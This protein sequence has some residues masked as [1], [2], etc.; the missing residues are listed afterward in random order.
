MAPSPSQLIRTRSALIPDA[1]GPWMLKRTSATDSRKQVMATVLSVGK[2]IATFPER[3]RT[4]A[5]GTV[6]AWGREV[7]IDL[8]EG[9]PFLPGEKVRILFDSDADSAKTTEKSAESLG[10]AAGE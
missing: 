10:A 7:D 4:A 5:V 2:R 3:L 6:R 8:P 9:H 1:T